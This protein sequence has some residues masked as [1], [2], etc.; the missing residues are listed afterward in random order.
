M[1]ESTV[2]V[3]I[4]PLI[5]YRHD[6]LGMLCGE[7]NIVWSHSGSLLYL[8]S[9]AGFLL[10]R[11]KVKH[12]TPVYNAE[13]TILSRTGSPLQ[14]VFTR[15]IL[16]KHKWPATDF[17]LHLQDFNLSQ[18][19]FY[20]IGVRGLQEATAICRI[21]KEDTG[22]RNLREIMEIASA[23]YLHCGIPMAVGQMDSMNTQCSSAFLPWWQ[24]YTHQLWTICFLVI[25]IWLSFW[26]ILYKANF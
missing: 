26:K 1:R 21:L 8:L 2:T 17:K 4:L 19:S 5:I 3:L 18:Y 9:C 22:Y 14:A 11:G 20:H 6:E 12:E 15:C 10:L 13:W 25:F 23:N 7:F 24:I 16:N